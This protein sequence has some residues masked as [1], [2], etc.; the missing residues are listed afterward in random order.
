MIRVVI[1]DDHK[2]VRAAWNIFLN[3]FEHI[4]V[5]ASCSDGAEAVRA[6]EELQPDIVL[7]DINMEGMSG[8]EATK[9]IC[10]QWPDVKVIGVSVHG[11]WTYMEKMFEAGARGY[12]TKPSI[13]NEL[14]NA[15][16]EVA[17]GNTYICEELR[18]KAM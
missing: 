6:V 15:I 3:R 2:E 11:A 10:G 8:I 17:R 4:L 12:V 9:I 7:M 1:T 16:S 13:A 5:V 18:A 14:I